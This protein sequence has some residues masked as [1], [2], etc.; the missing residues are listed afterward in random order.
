M[1]GV[2]GFLRAIKSEKGF[3]LMEVALAMVI[4]SGI[5]VL[6]LSY[7]ATGSRAIF[8]ADE[9]ATAESLARAQ[10]EYVR[11]QEYSSADWNYTV[12]SSELTSTDP[13]TAGWWDDDPPPLL[14][15]DYATYTVIVNTEP[16]SGSIDNGIQ[17][18]T[19]T[20]QNTIS[21]ET[22]EIF[23]LEGYRTSR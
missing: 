1:K 5:A 10:M 20:I 17:V 14:S 11:D 13:P 15:D 19:V 3:N 16:L 8:I 22:K 9:R 21:E 4:I 7:L 6:Y 2:K 12:T 18:I 23:T